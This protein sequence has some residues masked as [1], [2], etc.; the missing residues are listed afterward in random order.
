MSSRRRF[1]KQMGL[2]AGAAAIMP[3]WV[4]A[5]GDV[6][7]ARA[8]QPLTSPFL[9]PFVS[10]L[11][12]PPVLQPLDPFSTNRDVPIGT[13]FHLMRIREAMHSFHPDLPATSVWGYVG[14]RTD[15]NLMTPGPTLVTRVGVPT[16]VRFVNELPANHRGFGVPNM[17]VHRHGGFQASEDDGYPL[18]HFGPGTSRD[19]FYPE[20][21]EEDPR[22]TQSTLWYHDH[23]ID[24]TGPNVYRGLAGFNVQRDD[25]DSGD[26][27]DPSPEALRLPS[28]AYDIA[29]VFQ[30]RV[31]DR[32][33]QLV[34]D[35][36]AHDG[37][38][39]DTFLVNGAV[40]PFLRVKRRKYRFRFLN[41]ANARFF[42]LALSSGQPLVQVASEGGLLEFP[43][44]RPSIL[45]G[46]AERVDVIVDFSNYPQGSEL[47]LLN[48]AEQDDGRGPNRLGGP[49]TPLLKFIIDGPAEDASLVKPLLRHAFPP[50]TGPIVQRRLFEFS[51]SQGAW[52]INGNLWDPNRIVATPLLEDTEV[53]TL[54]NGGGGWWHPIYIHLS[55]FEI[56]SHNGA[57]PAPWE[58][59][60]KE[61][62]VLGPNDEV[63]I[64]VHFRRFRGRY[65]FHCHNLE[66][67]DMAMMARFD[68][69]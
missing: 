20:I 46:M 51:R 66:H 27:T 12:I 64:L 29:M 18:D 14:E 33:G 42:E 68:T 34:Y 47:Y 19:Y 30:D 17:T 60:K 6:F 50:V 28:G 44:P 63:E 4:K 1:L 65:V 57:P 3:R 22:E 43:L 37:M 9:R 24:F 45:M 26:E 15:G 55:L 35:Q 7:S 56:L 41:G 53:W 69:I 13:Q 5:S 52:A 10:D 39:G 67:E 54:K 40:Q 25:D 21:P 8:G 31:F 59:C 58:R 16:L 36:L 62:F 61:T 38:L 48:R 49:G 11:P 32:D 2:V 23:C